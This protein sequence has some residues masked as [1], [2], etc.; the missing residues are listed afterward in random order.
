MKSRRTGDAGGSIMMEY[1]VLTALVAVPVFL[2]WHG[3]SIPWYG[4]QLEYPGIYDLSTGEFKGIG[5]EIQGFFQRITSGIALPI[6]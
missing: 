1:I 3:A 6:P 2:V 4:G 5:L